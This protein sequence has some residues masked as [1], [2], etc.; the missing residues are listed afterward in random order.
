MSRCLMF[1]E[2]YNLNSAYGD[3]DCAV[4][5]KQSLLIEQ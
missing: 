3:L 4:G 5:K 1:H 2:S